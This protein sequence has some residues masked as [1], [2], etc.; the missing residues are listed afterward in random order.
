M[1]TNGRV[2]LSVTLNP[3]D[4]ADLIRWVRGVDA[5]GQTRVQAAKHALRR[6]LSL[7]V[8]DVTPQPVAESTRVA[9]LER[10]LAELR[11]VVSQVPRLIQSAGTGTGD[12]FADALEDVRAELAALRE[13]NRHLRE[14]NEWLHD[15][16]HELNDR[17][18]ALENGAPQQTTRTDA[19]GLP[20]L[21][22]T[23]READ[24]ETA[25]QAMEG[26]LADADEW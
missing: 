6:G 11:G 18:T 22:R 12:G 20:V 8:P 14:Q 5:S 15:A 16:K 25:Q 1:P 26:I 10:E 13:E 9:E 2:M 4:D 24:E 3:D 21:K 7:A 17:L 19:N 23:N